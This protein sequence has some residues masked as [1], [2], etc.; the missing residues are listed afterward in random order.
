MMFGVVGASKKAN[1]I[2]SC[3]F[4]TYKNKIRIR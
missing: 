3:T 1:I 4:D 2:S